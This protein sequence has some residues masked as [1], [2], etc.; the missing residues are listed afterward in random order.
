MVKQSAIGKDAA[1]LAPNPQFYNFSLDAGAGKVRDDMLT[2]TQYWKV[3][4]LSNGIPEIVMTFVNGGAQ[5]IYFDINLPSECADTS[6]ITLTPQWKPT[7]TDAGNVQFLVYAQ[8]FAHDNPRN[9]NIV[10]GGNLV[11]STTATASTTTIGDLVIGTE[12]TFTI[13]GSGKHITFC[14]MRK[15]GAPDTL[16]AS[17]EYLTMVGK[18]VVTKTQATA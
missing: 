4:E 18:A 9:V 11:L 1:T 2:P 3:N 14:I 6:A 16:A 17:I 15:A 13:G 8:R 12:D 5:Y 10:V 7:T